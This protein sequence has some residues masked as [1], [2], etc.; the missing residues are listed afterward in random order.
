V[1][2]GE[3]LG[4]EAIADYGI[5]VME[6]FTTDDYGNFGPEVI[7]HAPLEIGEYDVVFDADGNGNYDE[8]PDFVN[9]PNHPGFTVVSATVGVEVYPVDKSALLMPWLGLVLLL[10][11]A[12]AYLARLTF[13]KLKG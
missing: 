4:G 1:A 3:R 10:A 7:W 11:L 6:T 5:V 13:S 12:A 9:N 2:A 8:I